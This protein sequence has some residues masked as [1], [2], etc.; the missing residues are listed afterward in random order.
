MIVSPRSSE[1]DT[2]G[3]DL[4]KND[5]TSN[6]VMSSG[7]WDHK[8]MARNI[9]RRRW[10]RGPRLALIMQGWWEIGT[11]RAMGTPRP[12]ASTSLRTPAPSL[13][14]CRGRPIFPV[15]T[16]GDL[17]RHLLLGRVAFMHLGMVFVTVHLVGAGA[18]QTTGT[19]DGLQFQ[20][21]H[22]PLNSLYGRCSI[23]VINPSWWT[24]SKVTE[25]SQLVAGHYGTSNGVARSKVVVM[26]ARITVSLQGNWEVSIQAPFY[27]KSSICAT[28]GHGR[29]SNVKPPS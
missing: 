2:L 22:Y 21:C 15:I 11:W 10:H 13:V 29:G 8:R 18:H 7:P 9:K 12:T 17:K 16:N 27:I 25:E 1:M 14:L 5:C 24:T 23:L 20:N 4:G 26:V 28:H 6:H 3:S 19:R